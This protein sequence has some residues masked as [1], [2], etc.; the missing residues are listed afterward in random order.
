MLRVDGRMGGRA[1]GRARRIT[2][3]AVAVALLVAAATVTAL[4]MFRVRTISV[5]GSRHLTQNEVLRLAGVTKGTNIL[6]L[7]PPSVAR[8]LERDPWV[9]SATISKDLPSTVTVVVRERVPIAVARVGDVLRLVAADGTMLDE[10]PRDARLP[11][12]GAVKGAPPPSS[13]GAGA[14]ARAIAAMTPATRDQVSR[15]AVLSDGS[16]RVRLLGGAMVM[17]GTASEL[18]AKAV[19]LEA[20]LRWATRQGGH[21]ATADVHVPSNPTAEV[22][23]GPAQAP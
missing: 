9:L 14:A 6:S 15:V 5:R 17:Y 12:I 10:A 22:V 23:P 8:S 11:M 1:Q 18:R 16:L 4:S 20:L 3:V 13:A 21:L 7:S 2:T 19:S